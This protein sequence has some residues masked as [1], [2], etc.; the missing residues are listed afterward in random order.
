M[1]WNGSGD[2]TRTNSDHTGPTT[3]TQDKDGSIKITAARHDSH[4][5]DLAD[6][7]KACL[8]KNGENAM[9]GDLDMGGGNITDCDQINVDQLVLEGQLTATSSVV[10][11]GD[12]GV[13]KLVVKTAA[14]ASASATGTQGTITADAD[15]IYVCTATDTWKRVAIATW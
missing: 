8:A 11:I 2:F 14:P 5:Q 4:D 12:G 13:G 10:L 3:W 9:T 7:I 6:G 1:P 15:Y